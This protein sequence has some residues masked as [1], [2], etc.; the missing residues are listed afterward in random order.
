M[1]KKAVRIMSGQLRTTFADWSE[2]DL[3]NLF[4]M[5]DKRKRYLD[6]DRQTFDTF[7]LG[8]LP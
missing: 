8:E 7:H 4:T 6:D 3:D 1:H 5:L 2:T